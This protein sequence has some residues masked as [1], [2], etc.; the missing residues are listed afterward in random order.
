MKKII[1]SI[2]EDMSKE[3]I[4]LESKA[5]RETIANA[6][7]LAIKTNGDYIEF[8]Q[9][10]IDI[11]EEKLKWICE[12]CNKSTYNVNVDYL[13]HARCHLDCAFKEG[14]DPDLTQAYS[15]K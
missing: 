15:I 4:N 13:L 3:Q 7:V 6:I 11:K 1:L 9:E 14:Y 8:S 10:E 12:I 2:L 5:A